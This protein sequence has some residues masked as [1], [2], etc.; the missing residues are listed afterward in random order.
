MG[1][2][3][4]LKSFHN[5]DYSHSMTDSCNVF[6]ALKV[7]I[8]FAQEKSPP[9]VQTVVAIKCRAISPHMPVFAAACFLGPWAE[10]EEWTDKARRVIMERIGLATAG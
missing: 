9:S 1:S 3:P 8:T 10:D 7:L 2:I 6:S 4:G 5:V